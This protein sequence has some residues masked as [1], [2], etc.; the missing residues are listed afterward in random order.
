MDSVGEVIAFQFNTCAVDFIQQELS[1][2]LGHL[3]PDFASQKQLS[4]WF[5]W[6]DFDEIKTRIRVRKCPS[7]NGY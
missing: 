5:G 7:T 4:L 6:T 1:T 2:G 3:T